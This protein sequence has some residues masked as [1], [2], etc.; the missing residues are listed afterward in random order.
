MPGLGSFAVL[1]VLQ[2]PTFISSAFFVVVD[3]LSI[4]LVVL[5]AASVHVAIGIL[6]LAL[7]VRRV[8]RPFALV[9]SAVRPHHAALTMSH[10][11][12]PLA[13]VDGAR[14]VGIGSLL[15]LGVILENASQSLLALSGLEVLVR[16]CRFV[17]YSV[18]SSCYV[19]PDKSLQSHN[20]SKLFCSIAFFGFF[21]LNKD[22]HF[23]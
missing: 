12:A 19:A 5:P 7:A 9:L 3:A 17:F 10:P 18:L 1:L 16:L 23:A 21:F 20:A 11:T 15:D 2:P 22:F 13:C 14:S 4:G 6:E 8:E